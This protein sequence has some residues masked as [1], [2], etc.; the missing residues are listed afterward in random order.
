MKK[1]SMIIFPIVISSII[2][3]FI[4]CSEDPFTIAD[5]NTS[6]PVITSIEA[7]ETRILIETSV[8]VSVTAQQGDSYSWSA[9]DGSFDAPTSTTTNWTASSTGGVYKLTCTVTN[10]SG[11]RKASINMQVLETL[12]PDG[13]TG[14]W[15]FDTG[16][17]EE[18]NEIE[19]VGGVDVSITGDAVVGDGAALFEGADEEI[20]SAL[21]YPEAD[22]PMGPED[23][24]TITLWA[25]TEDEGLGFLFGRSFEGDYVEGAKGMYIEEGPVVF[26][27]AWVDGFGTEAAVNDGEWHHLAAVKGDGEFFIY[28]DGEEALAVELGEWS[29]DDETVVT[30]G[31]ASEEGGEWPGTFNG[32]MDD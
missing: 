16:F 22:A 11:S 31:A 17:N 10:S 18:V 3:M 24:F 20:E 8:Q 26:D 28:I 19:G 29:D 5:I 27:I 23:L 32:T 7:S 13:V 1:Y 30:L 12:L 4:R 25:K 2:I 9:A 14:Y 15:S 21:F 6:L